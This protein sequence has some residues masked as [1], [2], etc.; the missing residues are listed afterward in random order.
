MVAALPTIS[1]ILCSC[2]LVGVEVPTT[3]E[4]TFANLSAGMIICAVAMELFPLLEKAQG[5]EALG[6]ITIGFV[7]GLAL[8]YGA[9]PLIDKLV[10]EDDDEEED[11]DDIRQNFSQPEG[12]DSE[13]GSPQGSSGQGS[14]NNG[15]L[16]TSPRGV[17]TQLSTFRTRYTEY[18]ADAVQEAHDKLIAMP[19]HRMHIREHLVEISELIQAIRARSRRLYGPVTRL[20]SPSAIGNSPTDVFEGDKTVQEM[21]NS[22]EF[23]DE[24][25]HR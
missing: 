17:S 24:T 6:A 5:F 11:E 4:A 9:E 13:P 23:I 14:A 25:V 19:Q 10:G 7:A 22:A 18:E 2:C 16:P 3:V 12:H 1:M 20:G 21:E 15:E 8:V